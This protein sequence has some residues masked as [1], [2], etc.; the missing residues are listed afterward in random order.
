MV[1]LAPSGLCMSEYQ[2]LKRLLRTFSIACCAISLQ[3][4]HP[5]PSD[6]T[7]RI[8]RLD[9]I[10]TDACP[11]LPCSWRRTV[12]A[13]HVITSSSRCREARRIHTY[14][15]SRKMPNM[16]AAQPAD[17]GLY[18]TRGRCALHVSVGMCACTHVLPSIQHSR[19]PVCS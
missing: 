7:C 9:S 19:C 17:A 14:E 16:T 13:R 4:T 5:A 2:T 10:Q 15:R 3:H 12:L 6:C 18:P 8:R 11:P 1:K